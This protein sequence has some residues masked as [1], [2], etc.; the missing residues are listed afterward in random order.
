[1]EDIGSRYTWVK[2]LP[3]FE[4]LRQAL[5]EPE[6]RLRLG[7]EWLTELTPKTHFSQIDLEGTIF[8][9]QEIRFKKL[10]IPLTG[11]W[12]QLLVAEARVKA[13]CLMLSVPLCRYRNTGKR[14]T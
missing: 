5:L 11:I 6:D 13:C 10:S 7:D 4:G 14:T 1:M 12:L 3:T 9:G 8:D 2:A